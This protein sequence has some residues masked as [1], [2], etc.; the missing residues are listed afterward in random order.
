[1]N[2][3]KVSES[4]IEII[5]QMTQA[6]ANLAGNVHGGIIMKYIDNTAGIVATR[7]TQRNC[8]TASVDRIDFHHPVF[9]GD[10]L[11]V[12]SSV[13][14]VGKSSMEIGVKVE[15]ENFITGEIRH[16]ASAYLTFVSLDEF[17]KPVPVPPAVFETDVEKQR[18]EE[19]AE[20]K[21]MRLAARKN[22]S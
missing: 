22:C 13:N 10:L 19:A 17:G 3:K 18:N 20:R 9:I 12:K 4:C 14:Y 21:R 16:T 7:H 15:A 5:Q 1:M 8:V 6:E 2:P 11:H